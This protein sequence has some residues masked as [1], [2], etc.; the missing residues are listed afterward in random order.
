MHTVWVTSRSAAIV[1]AL[2]VVSA[3]CTSTASIDVSSGAVHAAA[4]QEMA[5]GDP[6]A[7]TAAGSTAADTAAGGIAA[8]GDSA[9][10]ATDPGAAEP[11]GLLPTDG[12]EGT[13]PPASVEPIK[14]GTVQPLQGG[15][16]D[17]GVPIL[18]A[19]QSYIDE[20]NARGGILGRP[21]ELVAY[22]ACLLCQDEAL[23]A[24]RRL[25]EQDNVF[26]IVNTYV[27]VVAF[28][29]VI[30][31][32]VEQ[33]VPL[34]QGG[35]ENQT[36]DAL[37]PVNFATAPPGRFY[38]RLLPEMAKREGITRVAFTYLDVPS[39]ANGIPL[40]RE[41]F[42]RQGIE[43][44]AEEPIG[45]AEDAVTNMDAAITRMRAAGANGVMATNPV[46]VI[47]G[48]LGADRQNWQVPW[49]G[50]AAWSRLVEDSCGSTCDEFVLTDTAGL[51]WIE[52]D[53][54]QMRQYVDVLARRYP[55]GE[56]TG[57][58]LAAW[59]GMQLLVEVLNRTGVD[60]RAA[61]LAE[62]NRV[63]NLDLGT[64]SLLTFNPDRHLGGSATVLLKLVDGKYV[65]AAGPLSYGE[66][67]L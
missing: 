45:A 57:H 28:Q 10:A 23:Q 40:L 53:T 38:L 36:S 31:Y 47:Y 24:V 43:V 19:T 4:S 48:R 29:S 14:I 52:R 49:I 34:I 59:V 15:Q 9:R 21:I 55:G 7:P 56:L 42:E 26:A 65:K 12:S 33:N 27:M 67:E 1:L 20:L 37:S 5:A 41:E 64:T 16:R 6:G 54:P 18:R 13:P 66:A 11:G 61:F 44:V 50:P 58:T 2:A 32:L 60:D 8:G 22:N 62:M 63:T 39:E 3:A 51:S 46:L 17:F 35:A 25:V 30:P